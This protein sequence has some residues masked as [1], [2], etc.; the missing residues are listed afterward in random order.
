MIPEN[1][2]SQTIQQKLMSL[3]KRRGF[4][5]Q[6]SEIYGGWEASYDFGPLGAEV[7][8]NLRNLWWDEFVT[9]RPD[10]VGLDSAI[11]SHPRVWEA[12]G[13]VASFAD[14]MVEDLV[15]HK[16]YR[17]DHLVD[18]ALNINS[19]GS[20]VEEFDKLIEENH[21]LSP[22]GN[23]LSKAKKFNN[24]VEV[25]VGT[26]ENEKSKAYLRGE[27]CQPIFYNYQLIKDSMRLKLPFAVA[28]IGK[29]FRNE[30]K[31]GPF[32]FRT[33]EFEQMELE[34]FINPTEAPK[35]FELLKKQS[36]EWLKN[37]GISEDKLRFREQDF[38]ERAHYNKIATDLEYNFEFGWKEFQ[39]LHYRGDWDLKRHGEFS[40]ND[41]TYKDEETGES[42]VPNVVEYS[43]GLNRLMLVLLSNAYYEDGERVV[44]R[45]DKRVAP[46]KVAVFPLVKNK[47]ELVEKARCI[48][49][50]LRFKGVSVAWD[51]RGNIG[52][53]YLSQ[54]EIGTPSCI[55]VDYQTLEDD[56]V[57]IRD[58]DTTKQE[59]VKV[60]EILDKV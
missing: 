47:P 2:D 53:R 25:E 59:R 55:T 21:I 4:V 33:R 31:V 20:S 22:D 11:I 40:G 46:Y 23:K 5:F 13:H 8:R 7:L 6:S 48:Y 36:F 18:A 35:H 15:T 19:D 38:K 17:A 14:A 26:L 24:L 1:K 10:T 43:I 9:R 45:L 57:T 39:G 30:I 42:Y 54:D 50:D 51:D 12:S 56:T 32:F 34:I 28:Q 44:L 27:T 58:R 16:R 41:F 52:K 3:C 60:S 49:E 37:L 29:A